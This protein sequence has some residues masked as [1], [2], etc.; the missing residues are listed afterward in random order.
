MQINN[1]NE[2]LFCF[3]SVIYFPIKRTNSSTYLDMKLLKNSKQ[4]HN[5]Q[6]FTK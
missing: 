3:T 2:M 1:F 4:S 5:C 6:E